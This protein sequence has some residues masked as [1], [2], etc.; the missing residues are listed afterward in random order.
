MLTVVDGGTFDFEDVAC[1]VERDDVALLSAHDYIVSEG[2][3]L[4]QS[5]FEDYMKYNEADLIAVDILS[6]P[7]SEGGMWNIGQHVRAQTG[8]IRQL[9]RGQAEMAQLADDRFSA[10]QLQLDEANVKLALLE[11]N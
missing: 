7:V 10:L 1:T 3:G 9:G 5:E 2:K 4:I 6:A 11:N 8:A